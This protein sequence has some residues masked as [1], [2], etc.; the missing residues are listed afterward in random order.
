MLASKLFALGDELPD[1]GPGADAKE[2]TTA[3]LRAGL[4]WP[5]EF[6]SGP[7]ISGERPVG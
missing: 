3:W 2:I 4:R 6:R 5:E 1:G 7:L